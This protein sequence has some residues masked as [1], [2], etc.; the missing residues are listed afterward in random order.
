MVADNNEVPFRV[1]HYGEDKSL[2]VWSYVIE[3]DCWG[4]NR[5]DGTNFDDRK[6]CLTYDVLESGIKQ[7]YDPTWDSTFNTHDM[8]M[9]LF[10]A[11]FGPIG[12][13]DWNLYPTVYAEDVKIKAHRSDTVMGALNAFVYRRPM[14]YRFNNY[15]VG[16]VFDVHSG[17]NSPVWGV[18]FLLMRT[19]MAPLPL[20]TPRG[21]P[22][23]PPTAGAGASSVAPASP[24]ASS[25]CGYPLW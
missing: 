13:M 9:A 7:A 18:E 14:G 15:F 20:P 19:P 8:E 12:I 2:T 6:E 23:C 3:G 21:S 11:F 4:I 22:P 17:N 24:S 5:G 25:G 10:D 1:I 16:A